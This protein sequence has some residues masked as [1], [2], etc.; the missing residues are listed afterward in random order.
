[1]NRGLL[2][3]GSAEERVGLLL[4]DPVGRRERL[5]AVGVRLNPFLREAV[6]A[7]RAR[8]GGR[9]TYAAVQFEGVDWDL[10]DV[11]TFELIRS[12]EVADVFREGVRALTAGDKPVAVTVRGPGR[13]HVP[14]PAL[15]AEG[16]VR[17]GGRPLPRLTRSAAPGA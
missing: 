3:G 5:A 11:M 15:G 7:V 12:A 10:F 6:A 8:F 17:R 14:G 9:V 1:M 13:H 2:E 16:R 4:A